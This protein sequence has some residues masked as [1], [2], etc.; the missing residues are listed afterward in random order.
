MSG[1]DIEQLPVY[2]GDDLG[3]VPDADGT[4]FTIWAPTASSVELRLFHE[5]GTCAPGVAAVSDSCNTDAVALPYA[6][7]QLRYHAANGT[8]SIR[9][10]DAPHGTYYDY[11]VGFS[12]G[13]VNRTADPWARAAGANGRRSMVVDLAR[14]NPE[15]W[16]R[17]HAP[18]IP[19]NELVVWETHIGDFSN[20]EHS[21][22]PAKHRG[23]YLAFTYDDTSVDGEGDFP[24]CMAYLK[25]L[26]VTVV[27]LMPFYDFGSV[28]ELSGVVEDGVQGRDSVREPQYNWGYDPLNYNVP[29]G[30][31][32]TDPRDGAVRIRECKQMIQALHA[33]GFKVVMDVVYNHMYS[34]DNWLERTVPGYFCRRWPDAEAGGGVLSNG[35]G[36]GND[37]AAEHAMMRKYI[38]DS[39]AYWASEYHVDGFRF[40]LMGLIDVPTMNAVRSQLDALPGG[41]SILM[42]GEPWAADMTAVEPGTVLADKQGLDQLD[43]RIGFFCDDTRDAVR[44][45][46]F[47]PTR[48]GY[49]SGEAD[50]FAS[51][52]RYAVDGWRGSGREHASVGQFV[53]YVSAHDDLTLWDK[54]CASM[55]P[56]PRRLDYDADP[57]GAGVARSAEVADMMAANRMAA[58]IVASAAGVPFMLSGEEFARTKYGCGNSY[59]QPAL[60]NQLDWRRARRQRGLVAYYRALIRWRRACPALCGAPRIVVPRHDA[61]V[62]FRVGED[63]VT[64]NPTDHLAE[65]P[66]DVLQDQDSYGRVLPVDSRTWHCI[67]DS[68]GPA[69]VPSGGESGR[70]VRRSCESELC[71]ADGSADFGSIPFEPA[72]DVDACLHIPPHTFLIWRRAPKDS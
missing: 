43:P 69:P 16:E 28:D 58:G 1:M 53:Q 19:A 34:P 38:V 24:T 51:A 30:L 60:L 10:D 57:S 41:A 11:R 47:Y 7:H 26:G 40:D 20:D 65:Q 64:I 6:T 50:E 17:D 4:T 37:M 42:Y 5:G 9:V 67:L 71:H 3:A 63:C 23:K 46:I 27:Q 55:R 13:R 8:W 48:A 18:Q 22:I 25:Q 61:V 70:E 12:D 45:H 54:L 39:V 15:G 14:T 52:I 59:D 2:E 33:N 72:V 35:S 29:E 36:C 66:T 56:A 21:G 31:Y 62:V 32:S 49:V 68:R 44:G